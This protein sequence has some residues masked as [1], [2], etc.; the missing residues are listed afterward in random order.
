MRVTPN[1]YRTAKPNNPGEVR[2]GFSS[3]RVPGP[4]PYCWK[5]SIP[6]RVCIQEV[7]KLTSFNS[8]TTSSR[9]LSMS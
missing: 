9:L 2:S 8:P 1:A 6:K 7:L 5:K 3:S 4:I